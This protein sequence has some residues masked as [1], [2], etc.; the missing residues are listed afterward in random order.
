MTKKEYDKLDFFT[1]QPY[2]SIL[3]LL[4]KFEEGLNFAQLNYVLSDCPIRYPY[5]TSKFFDDP[6]NY[7]R[8]QQIKNFVMPMKKTKYPNNNL[9]NFL[10]KLLESNTI[11]KKKVG[12]KSKYKLSKN[13]TNEMTRLENKMS[14]DC[15]TEDLIT[16]FRPDLER[17]TKYP[18][19]EDIVS[20]VLYGFPKK[21]IDSLPDNDRK[22]VLE[23]LDIIEKNI[24]EVE[25]ITIFRHKRLIERIR[26]EKN[27]PNI[28]DDY[29]YPFIALSRYPKIKVFASKKS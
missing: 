26:K 19:R 13:I 16:Y 11:I 17:K 2:I 9:A 28:P 24:R 14:I 15:Y 4:F 27:D 21:A 8:L 10:K 29:T 7:D 23:L 5:K 3:N 6:K 18:Y 20:I 1:K 25:K 22:R 12:K